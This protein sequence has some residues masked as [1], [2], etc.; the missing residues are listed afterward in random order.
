MHVNI[1]HIQAWLITSFFVYL[2]EIEKL[3]LENVSG[4]E[5]ELEKVSITLRTLGK[6]FSRQ[7]FEIFSLF[8]PENKICHFLQIVSFGDILHEMSN[9]VFREK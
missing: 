8:F 1:S 4:A 9:S 5:E 3:V 6:I 7:H 2:Q